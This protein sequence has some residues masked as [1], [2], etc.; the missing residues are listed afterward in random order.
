[1]SKFLLG[2]IDLYFDQRKS[3]L[4]INV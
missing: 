3:S 2:E 1:M 4:R